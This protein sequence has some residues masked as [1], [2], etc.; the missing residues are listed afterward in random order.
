MTRLGRDAQSKSPLTA[1]RQIGEKRKLRVNAPCFD[2]PREK[3]ANSSPKVRDLPRSPDSRTRTARHQHGG[4]TAPA[5]AQAFAELLPMSFVPTTIP[6]T[7]PLLIDMGVVAAAWRRRPDLTPWDMP[8]LLRFWSF[9]LQ[10]RNS[11]GAESHEKVCHYGALSSDETRRLLS[12]SRNAKTSLP[13]IR[14]VRS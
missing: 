10:R 7:P 14:E 3:V 8:R 1:S 6:Q 12:M 5:Q 13:L 11:R 4:H 9:H 2:E